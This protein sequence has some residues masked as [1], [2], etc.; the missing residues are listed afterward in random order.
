MRDLKD[1]FRSLAATPVVTA[2]AILSLALGI[3]ANTAIFSILD[4]LILRTLPVKEPQRLVL[5][6]RGSWTNPIWEAIR[7]RQQAFDGAMAWSTTR[8]NLAQGGQTE[9]VDGIW[10]SGAFFDVLGVPAIL[11][12]TFALNDDRRG[13]GPDGP[14]AVISYNFWQRRFGGSVD[15]VGKPLLV[16]RVTYTIIGV[17]PPDFFGTEVGRK[18]DVAIPIGTEPLVRGKETSLDRRS[19]WWLSIMLRLKPGQ[20]VDAATASL[21]GLQPQIRE[22]TMPQ[23]W[24]EQYKKTYLQDAFSLVPAATGSSGL[25]RR[26]QQPLTAIM[27]VVALV[28][29]IACANIA[30]LLLARANARR[31]ELSVRVALGASKLRIARQLLTESLLLSGTGALIGLLMARWGSDLLVRQLS[32]TTNTVFLELGLD[33]RTL[34]FTALVAVTTA[35]LFG[36]AP[37]LRATRVQP[38]EA[39]K[40][41]G[42][43]VAGE[44][45]GL[46]NLLVVVQVALSVILVVAAGLFVRTFSSLANVN[47]GFDHRPVLV[48]HVNAQRLQLDL[49]QRPELFERLRQAAANVPGVSTAAIS[50]VTPVSGSTWNNVIEIP[51]MPAA[52][53]RERMTNINLL[54]T[55]WFATMGTRVIAGRDFTDRD[56]A[57]GAPVAIVNEA[58][59]RKYFDRQNPIGRRVVQPGS[60]TRP[61]IDREIVGYV[62]DAVYR[63]LREPV[64]PTMYLALAQHADP[65]SSMSISVR[66]AGGSP[67]LLTKSLAAGLTGVN[68]DVAITLRLLSEQVNASL[69][70]ERMVA[71]LSGFFGGLAL[72][73]AGLG[74]YGITSYAVSRRR[75]EIGIRMALGAAPGGVIRMVLRRV[76]LLVGAGVLLGAGV[77]VWASRFV[78]TLLYGLQPRDPA[79][80]VL[81][82]L[83]L[84]LIG[85]LAGWIPA[86]RAARIDPA[87]VLREG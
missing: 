46:G 62:E 23:D 82:A 41:R 54:S 22:V 70:Q 52:P 30:N 8:F 32:T 49:R 78:S 1:A 38:N 65:P 61:A 9:M 35:V 18:I 83:V 63:A 45:F 75:T 2:V 44:R 19:N 26:Y 11:G 39:L 86:R 5:I 73:L 77:S 76:A 43:G 58:F 27:V 4:S 33:W 6:D 13:G 47:L 74:L 71:M 80:L 31:H 64:P 17:M 84:S 20:D 59:A 81:A 34:G 3:G 21:R 25:R 16:E 24:A 42:R 53:D 79:T 12:R 29:L 56:V 87:R 60:P 72:L 57:G 68:K 28:L 15:A 7:E 37:A 69:I 48:A 51:G 67:A 40:E 55:S 10:A 85:A 14:V 66:A 50:A 36:V